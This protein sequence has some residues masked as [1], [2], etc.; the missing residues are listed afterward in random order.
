[1]EE[2]RRRI[3]LEQPKLGGCLQINDEAIMEIYG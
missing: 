1:M 2:A 3:M